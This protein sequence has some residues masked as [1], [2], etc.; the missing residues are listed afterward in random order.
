MILLPAGSNCV[1]LLLYVPSEP[2]NMIEETKHEGGELMHNYRAE[3]DAASAAENVHL[4][5]Q[6]C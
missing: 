3:F 6:T 2:I 5:G 1:R 4:T